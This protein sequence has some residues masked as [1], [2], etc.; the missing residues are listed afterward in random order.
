VIAS[1]IGLL[2]VGGLLTLVGR[3]APGQAQSSVQIPRLEGTQH[4]N[5]SGVWQ[6]LNEA[7]WDLEAHAAR[8]A[9]VT[10]PGVATGSPVPNAPVLALGATAGIPGSLGVVEGDHEVRQRIARGLRPRRAAGLRQLEH[11][12]GGARARLPLRALR[13]AAQLAAGIA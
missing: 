9:W 10:H 6:A 3:P 7:N 5:L 4:P 8:T 12:P 2:V 13:A 1:V 11:D